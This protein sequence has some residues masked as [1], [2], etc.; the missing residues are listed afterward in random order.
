MVLEGDSLITV[1]AFKVWEIDP[2]QGGPLSTAEESNYNNLEDK[3]VNHG[4]EK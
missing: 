3:E 1:N 4:R 2:E